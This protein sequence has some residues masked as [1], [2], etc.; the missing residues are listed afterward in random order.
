MTAGMPVLNL[1]LLLYLLT[2][3]VREGLPEHR[4]TCSEYTNASQQLKVAVAEQGDAVLIAKLENKVEGL[5][6]KI[7]LAAEG[8]PPT[9]ESATLHAT[10][11]QHW[12]KLHKRYQCKL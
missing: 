10:L 3:H 12:Y 8:A 9:T 1:C 11:P 2:A 5:Y 4:D 6:T 7:S